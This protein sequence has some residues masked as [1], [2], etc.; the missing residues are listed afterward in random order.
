MT[1]GTW[2]PD[3]AAPTPPDAT[4]LAHAAELGRAGAESF[5]EQA[6]PALSALQPWMRRRQPDWAPHL[7]SLSS[8]TII[9]LV[10]FFT[11][12]E[13]HWAGW[14]GGDRNPVVWLCK[15]LKTRGE[16]PDAE[17]TQWIKAHTDN[18]FLPYGN[19]LA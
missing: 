10:R 11:L 1:T 14:E 2:N 7:S 18:R 17:L 9:E 13:Q 4:L 5:P 6:D 15:E 19:P 3:A 12:A 8:A 16:F